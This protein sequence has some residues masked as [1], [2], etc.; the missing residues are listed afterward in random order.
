MMNESQQPRLNEESLDDDLSQQTYDLLATLAPAAGEAPQPSMAFAKLQAKLKTQR[1]REV[2]SLSPLPVQEGQVLTQSGK[3]R[4][5]ARWIM[6]AVAA[7][8]ALLLILPNANVLA[9]QF[10]SL[11]RVQQFQPVTINPQQVNRNLVLDLANFGDTQLQSDS[12]IAYPANPTKAEVEQY[13]HFSFLLPKK[14]PDGVGNTV[15][16]S[17]IREEHATFVFNMT[18][19]RAYLKKIGDDA[20][21][22]P[23][24]LEN[25]TYSITLSPGAIAN[26]TNGCPAADTRGTDATKSGTAQCNAGSQFSLVEIPS[27]T[28]D[29]TG[30]ASINDLRNF[31]LSLPHLPAPV[32]ELLSH[33]NVQNGTV[34]VPMPPQANSQ[35]VTVQGAQG[36]LLNDQSLGESVLLWQTHN[37]VYVITAHNNSRTQL[38]DA[39]NSLG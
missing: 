22:I 19:A 7:G 29:S 27:P 2:A 20:I 13:T 15:H 37:M 16:F 12:S 11:F 8:L 6:A 39:A 28:I 18:K 21:A 23:A 3:R 38:L 33:V 24:Q 31:L 34:P 4:P 14:L 36:V 25:A 17:I 1:Y 26:Y 5:R 10:F 30:K 9:Q 35:G 32:R